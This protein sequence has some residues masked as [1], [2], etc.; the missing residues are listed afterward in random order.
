MSVR[1]AATS[2]NGNI[3]LCVDCDGTFLRT[4]LLH[5]AVLNILKRRPWM[6]VAM[7]GWLLAGKSAF[8]SRVAAEAGL[9]MDAMPAH[10]DVLAL[11]AE[12]RAS[13][14]PVV[15]ATAADRAH[16][17]ALAAHFDVFDAI[18]SSGD[19][20]N[21]SSHA[22]AAELERR[23]GQAGFDYVGN[24]AAD[25][26]VWGRSRRSYVVAPSRGLLGAIRSRGLVV[27]AVGKRDGK[28]RYV[29]KALRP[30]QWMKNLL[31]LL[32][33]L[34]GHQ[35]RPEILGTVLLAFVS[36]SLCASAVYVTN[37][38]LDLDSDR[39]HAR[40]RNRPF[41]SG[42]LSIRAGL[43]MVPL[44]FAGSIAVAL[45]VNP[46]FLLVLLLY[47]AMTSAYSFRLKQQVIVDV[48]LLAML[49]TMR[50]LGGSAATYVPPSFW[51][52]AFSMFLFFS[53]ALV[54]RYSE[55]LPMVAAGK[56]DTLAGR[57]YRASDLP[58]LMAT[59]VS[60]GMSAVMVLAFYLD[61]A[62]T[63]AMYP[64]TKVILLAPVLILYWVARL[65]MKTHRDEMHEDP[66]LFAAKDWQTLV[67]AVILG[68]LFV[69]ASTHI[70]A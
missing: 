47:A 56:A 23:F 1:D 17:E 52:L 62:K 26:A 10:E 68:G 30:H 13:G 9:T 42:R 29:I 36:F 45:A 31:V 44:L 55:L 61:D 39:R 32:P 59:G 20:L 19:G 18:V 67:I 49:Y 35:L 51:L 4:D 63:R 28:L 34:A 43:A 2:M 38:L 53:L 16:A 6:I 22:K 8:K 24:A 5:E 57:G 3:P 15:L 54:K 21:L 50:I 48:I 14:R 58:V 64:S 12:A 69:L 37:D 66:V 11:I 70:F 33:P 65:W 40:K 25:L 60:S 7:V 27:D 41:A 46:L